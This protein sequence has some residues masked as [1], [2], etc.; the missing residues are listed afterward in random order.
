MKPFL[1]CIIAL[2]SVSGAVVCQKKIR[3]TPSEKTLACGTRIQWR[4][5][6]ADAL[7]EAAEA[8]R[9]VFWY[10]PTVKGSKMDR[11]DVIHHYMRSGPF[12]DADVEALINARFI[13][14]QEIPAGDL[15]KQYD[16]KQLKFVEPGFLVLAPDGTATKTV[17]RIATL[18]SEWF[19]FQLRNALQG[20]ESWARESDALRA[21]RRSS[22]ADHL[23]AQL[24]AEG[25][26]DEAQTLLDSRSDEIAPLLKA[27]LGRLSRRPEL[28]ESAWKQLLGSTPTPPEGA[29]TEY[30]RWLLWTGRHEEAAKQTTSSDPVGNEDADGARLFGA[31]ALLQTGKSTEARSILEQLAKLPRSNRYTEKASAEW[32]RLGPASRAFETFDR[33]PDDAFVAAPSGTTIPRSRADLDLVTRRSLELLLRHQREDGAFDDSNY[34]FGGTASLPNV[35]AA[36]T[37]LAA[38]AIL[39]WKHLDPKRSE[40][41]VEGACSYLL[42]EDHIALTDR[43][44]LIWAHTYRMTFFASYLKSNGKQAAA[45]RR[46]CQELGRALADAQL[47]GGAYRH[48]YPNPFATATVVH[49]WHA[50]QTIGDVPM[51]KGVMEGA[52]E[53]LLKCRGKDG[54]FTYGMGRGQGRDTP[55]PFAAGRMPL[56]ELAL[57]ILGASDQEKLR[58]AIDKSFEY[59]EHLERVRKVDDHADQYGN[60]GFFFWYNL[61]GRSAAIEALDDRAEQ[62]RL[63]AKLLDTILSISE[64]DGAFVDSH[65]LGK[66]YG[67]AMALIC[68][69]SCLPE[70]P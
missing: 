22:T 45:V 44:E 18:N 21:A 29:Q 40:A 57:L 33:L 42:N 54:S 30:V 37:A 6:V 9:P 39:D 62:A 51:G 65:E 48:E 8:D 38:M 17:D 52:A 68:L 41:A 7:R 66:T 67:T 59:H 1:L 31:I 23:M 43:N 53:A 3:E 60:G 32:Q 28:A 70:R 49:A 13:P 10:V 4:A 56:C 27:R 34:D 11:K 69:R 50:V 26:W 63:R 19:L 24:L 64:L 58:N 61:H 55:M 5:S 2:F 36:G 47:K 20:S 46:K 14:V 25:A 12:Q 15:Q 16:L 35:Y